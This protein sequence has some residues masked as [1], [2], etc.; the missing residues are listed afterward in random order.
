MKLRYSIG[1][2]LVERNINTLP[3]SEFPPVPIINQPSIP[4]EPGFG[5]ALRQALEC[6]SEDSSRYI[7]Q[8]ACLDVRETRQHYV[9]GTNGRYL[10]SANS[11]CFDLKQSIVIPDSNFLE[12]TDFLDQEPSSLSLEPGVEAEPARNGTPAKE[13]TPGWVKLESGQ[14]T[15]ITREI[16]GEFPNWKQVMPITDGKWTRVTLNEQALKQLLLIT[17]SLPGE[18]SQ[19]RAVRLRVEAH[20]LSVEG[21]NKDDDTWTSIPV[22]AVVS[23]KPVSVALNR[24]YLLSALCFGLNKIEIADPLSPVVFSNGGK[25]MVIMPVNLEGPEVATT[26]APPPPAAEQT[27]PSEPEVPTQERTAVMPT[28]T[29]ARATTPEPM[30]TFQPV[31]PHRNGNS[32]GNGNGN[33][34]GS[35]IKSLVEHVE[36][37]KENLKGVIRDLN[38]VI[39]TVK[40]AEKEKRTNDKEIDAIRTKLRQIQNV[41]I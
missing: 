13:S 17:P 33:G 34:N 40:L 7:L 32:N 22:E 37:I 30:T 6:C 8:G 25:K 2:N 12:W 18:E 15:F 36:Q 41:T 9:V 31:E 19:N 38:N 23:G 16:Q 5:L 11:L 35:V 26:P 29:A 1:G 27:A 20:Q 28:T 21:Q 4:L 10:F 14:W 24:R 3:A 39:D